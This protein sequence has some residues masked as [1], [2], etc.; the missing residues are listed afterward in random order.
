M[1]KN[2][3]KFAI[4]MTTLMIV[5][6]LF[7]TITPVVSFRSSDTTIEL[8]YVDDDSIDD[9]LVSLIDDFEY[10]KGVTIN[11]TRLSRAEAKELYQTAS[12]AGKAP[13]LIEGP[14]TWIPEFVTKG[15]ILPLAAEDLQEDYMSEALR[16]V[17]YYEFQDSQIIGNSIVYYGFPYRLDLQAF[18]YNVPKST[19]A[20]I[21][22]TSSSWDMEAFKTEITKVNDQ[23]DPNNKIFGFSYGEFP[24]SIEPLFFGNN[25]TKFDGYIV[26]VPHTKIM[27]EDSAA[28]L[29]FIYDFTNTLRL[30]PFYKEEYDKAS[31]LVSMIASDTYEGFVNQGNIISTFAFSSEIK[32]IL[33]G[34]QFIEANSLGFGPTPLVEGATGVPLHAYAFMLNGELTGDTKTTV[35][36]LA[37]KLT[38]TAAMTNNANNEY[39]MPA[40]I[41]AYSGA[42]VNQ[43]KNLLPS[44]TI[45]PISKY[46]EDTQD[47]LKTEIGN[48]LYGNQNGSTTAK[49]LDIK[50]KFIV[51]TTESNP[52]ILP[53]PPTII[54]P[55]PWSF[56]T[57]VL[58]LVLCT[59]VIIYH[60][61]KKKW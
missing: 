21:P 3:T 8:W 14:T 41:G 37:Q 32:H 4:L 24:W 18:V 7:L 36:E 55:T 57:S 15:Y 56:E 46:W 6:A 45:N 39:L 27:D 11:A 19:T 17:S 38:S 13:H 52:P 25:G 1:K 16:E 9:T 51:P 2:L 49:A 50:Y 35:I 29:E 60:R 61:K 44:V 10:E 47:V 53:A 40:I 33:E 43:Y 54:S 23:S 48:M 26:D 20:T 28:A 12:L 30:T 58:V 59:I 22:S 42:I 31:D 5:I 34:S